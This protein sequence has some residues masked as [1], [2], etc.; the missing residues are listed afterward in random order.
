M[1]DRADPSTEPRG[2]PVVID[3]QVDV[4]PFTT[5]LGPARFYPGSPGQA[6]SCQFVQEN[7]GGDGVRGFAKLWVGNIH[8]LSFI[9]QV[10]FFAEKWRL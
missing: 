2:T 4:A 1:L 9:P 3:H 8:G 6:M 7:A 5:T 10:I